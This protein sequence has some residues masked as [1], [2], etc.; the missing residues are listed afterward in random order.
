[1]PTVHHPGRRRPRLSAWRTLCS[2]LALSGATIAAGC[3]TAPPPAIVYAQCSE[4]PTPAATGLAALAAQADRA[5]PG[6]Q[7]IAMMA[8]FSRQQPRDVRIR[9]STAANA[10]AAA[11][12]ADLSEER[13]KLRGELALEPA[14]EL[15]HD[16]TLTPVA[17]AA[18]WSAS[19]DEVIS[20]A[21]VRNAM[22]TALR[23]GL[24]P[25]IVTAWL[26]PA[27]GPRMP[28][29]EGRGYAAA[30]FVSEDELQELHEALSRSLL[31]L[32]AAAPLESF[33]VSVRSGPAGIVAAV[34]A[35]EP[36]RLPLLVERDKGRVTV[37]AP[38]HHLA[39]PAAY[40]VTPQRSERLSAELE[41]T[42]VKIVVPCRAASGDLEVL[43]GGGVFA[44]L[45]DVC[46]P[47]DPRWT[48]HTGDIGPAASALVEVEQR[49]FELLNRERRDH[50]LAPVIWDLT[51][52][53]M[54]R[55]HARDMAEHRFVSHVGFDGN[56]LEHRI[57]DAGLPAART[58]ENVGRSG[59]P[60]EMHY[61]FMTSP[62]H[63]DN[64]LAPTARYAA[65]GAARD[66]VT[67]EL[68]F[69]QVLYERRPEQM[70]RRR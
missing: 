21:A 60:G 42:S 36:P 19:V 3:A 38:W 31:E 10:L 44:S 16:P 33:A 55:R 70:A 13:H 30:T 34:A 53:E 11:L 29:S 35:I 65:V 9:M 51:A 64:L 28:M 37:T 1:V 32:A 27:G 69:T 23:S 12:A 67:K 57:S 66:P 56:T 45:V 61:G 40:L 22:V 49:A 43:G 14:I 47:T 15:R 20:E 41:G 39:K 63:R 59:G 54:A 2:I 25:H 6:R 26:R 50:G 18:A 48:I 62:G 58:F 7:P 8:A 68:Y 24:S 4:G 46:N 5:A 52:L 17:E